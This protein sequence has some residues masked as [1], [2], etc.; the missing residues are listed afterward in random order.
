MKTAMTS[1]LAKNEVE[2]SVILLDPVYI[3]IYAPF[4]SKVY[5]K[6]LPIITFSTNNIDNEYNQLLNLGVK[7][8]KNLPNKIEEL[9]LF[10]M[11]PTKITF[12]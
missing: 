8:I 10:L 11:I 1:I 5:A 6:K 2:G 7:F 12:S 4:L 3:E 9:R